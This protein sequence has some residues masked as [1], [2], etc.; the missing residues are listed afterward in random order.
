MSLMKARKQGRRARREAANRVLPPEGVPFPLQVAGIGVRSAAQ[1]VDVV[2]TIITLLT[3]LFLVGL[4]GRLPSAIVFALAVLG[5]FAIRVPYY[6]VTELAWNGQTLG[7]RVLKIKVVSTDGGPLTTHAIVVRNLMKEAEVF[8]PFSL[9]LGLGNVG[10]TMM[11]G[12][13]L[14]VM[15]TLAIP[16][17]SAYRKRLGDVLAGTHVVH[18]PQPML[19]ADLSSEKEREAEFVFSS[20]QLDHYGT[21]ELQTLE[22]LLRAQTADTVS[23][24]PRVARSVAEVVAAI[25]RKIDYPEAIAP[26]YH[27]AFLRAF[28]DRQRAHLEQR[29]LFGEHRQDKHYKKQREAG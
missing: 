29:R 4:M 12:S 14:W 22:G 16:L 26:A 15:I 8:F 23:A 21:H 17:F 24:N 19:L 5:A 6:I 20:Q 9:L 28:Y 3:F 2:I 27:Y 13:L 11:L 25:C 10:P 7:K 18:L 1:L